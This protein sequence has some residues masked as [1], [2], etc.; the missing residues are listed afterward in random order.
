MRAV[1]RRD[2][3]GT[4]IITID[5]PAHTRLQRRELKNPAAIEGVEGSRLHLRSTGA[6][7]F[8]FGTK[9]LETGDAHGDSVATTTLR[10]SGY[11]AIEPFSGGDAAR[12]LIPVTVTPDRAPVVRVGA[13][14]RDLLLPDNLSTVNV[15]ASASDD[16]ALASL[17]LRYTRVSGSGEQFEFV[18]GELPVRLMRADEKNWQ[19]AGTFS[20]PALKLE[21]GDSLVYRVVARDG[22]PGEAGLSASDTYYIEIA[23]PGQVPLEG[24]EMPP[25][26]E[27]YALS[28]QMIVLKIQRLRA[29]AR[30]GARC[31][32]G[33]RPRSRRS[34]ARCANSCS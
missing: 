15:E 26:R 31:A 24:F 29:R 6:W 9:P 18:E 27:R 17:S 19:A 30:P 12:R 34:S 32:G 14:A 3:D 33:R 16:F 13:P 11:V 20:L 10:E 21:P 25:D 22:R 1:R 5:P 28:Q 4:P 7:R 23:G 2:P 8:R